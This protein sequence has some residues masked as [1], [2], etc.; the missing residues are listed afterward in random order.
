MSQGYLSLRNTSDLHK[1][2]AEYFLMDLGIYR[3]DAQTIP[4]RH[5][6]YGSRNDETNYRR[7]MEVGHL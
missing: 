7:N 3:A 5:R 6:L 2:S 1:V 4:N